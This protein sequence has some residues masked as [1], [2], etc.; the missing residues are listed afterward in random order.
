[1]TATELPI[2]VAIAVDGEPDAVPEAVSW[3]DKYGRSIGVPGSLSAQVP[4]EAGETILMI[5]SFDDSTQARVSLSITDVST[6][7]VALTMQ[8][9]AYHD[10]GKK[11]STDQGS[12]TVP[13]AASVA[14]S[15]GVTD[16]K[17]ISAFNEADTAPSLR[18]GFVVIV[19]LS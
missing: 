10:G 16:G 14:A 6:T 1:M 18:N 19:I 13:V 11:E 4:V 12:H 7:E 3:R 15:G 5:A 9:I 2:S 17:G 8:T